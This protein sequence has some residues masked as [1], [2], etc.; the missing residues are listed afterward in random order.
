MALCILLLCL[1]AISDDIH[2]SDEDRRPSSNDDTMGRCTLVLLQTF[3]RCLFTL[4]VLWLNVHHLCTISD[5]ADEVFVNAD[6]KRNGGHRDSHMMS[7]PLS[8]SS[9]RSLFTLFS[10]WC[11]L[12]SCLLS[13]SLKTIEKC[14][15]NNQ[16]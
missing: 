3:I 2:K 9:A 1:L 10:H 11:S 14:L 7:T 15:I 4:V 13:I 16:L 8:G 6:G 5:H 12:I